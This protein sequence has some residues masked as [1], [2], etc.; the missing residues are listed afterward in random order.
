MK[1]SKTLIV[2]LVIA[3]VLLVA[4]MSVAGSYNGLVSMREGVTTKQSDIDTNLT[5]RADLIPNLVASVKGYAAHEQAAIDSVTAARAALSGAQSLADKAAANDELTGALNRL[6]VV[7]ENYPD[8]KASANFQ[9]LMDEL[10]GT[11]NRLA[12]A[13]QDYN[14]AAKDYNTAIL[15]FPRNIIAGMFG[16]QKADYFEA[17]EGQKEVPKVEF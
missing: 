6:L 16:F 9:A 8:L 13:R 7:V 11:E 14:A 5:R 2:V 4:G 3:G 12:V 1:I 15:S 17:T 10:A